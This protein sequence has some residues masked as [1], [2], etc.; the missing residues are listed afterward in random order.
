MSEDEFDRQGCFLGMLTLLA[1]LFA[2]YVVID[3]YAG[4]RDM[5]HIRDLQRR[6]GQLES[7][8]Q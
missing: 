7:E 1:V 8:R 6:V 4:W 2:F 3:M 5:H